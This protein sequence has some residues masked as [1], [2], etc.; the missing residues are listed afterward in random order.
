VKEATTSVR[1]LR[2]RVA[3]LEQLLEVYE[4]SAIATERELERR[5]ADRTIELAGANEQL[6]QEVEERRRAERAMRMVADAGRIM[7]SSL[8]YRR[9][10]RLLIDSILPALGDWCVVD[11]VEDRWLTRIAWGHV[12]PDKQAVLE[13]LNHQYPPRRGSNSLETRVL[14]TGEPLLLR[15]ISEAD[16]ESYTADEE[17]RRLLRE[18]GI[19]SALV[20]PFLARD[21][22]VGSLLAAARDRQL[23]ADELQL[24]G[25]FARRAAAAIDNAALYEAALTAS[26]AKSDFLAVMSHELRTPLNAI[27]GYADLLDAEVKGSLNGEQHRLLE[28][29]HA[30]AAHQLRI[31]EE[32][33]TFVRVEE[34]RETVQ[35]EATELTYLV[36]EVAALIMPQVQDKGLHFER[37]QIP[38]M[39]VLVD[40]TKLREILLSL[41]SNAVKF[42]RAGTIRLSGRVDQGSLVLEVEDSGPG[43]APADHERIFDPFVQIEAPLTRQMGGTGLGLTVARRLAHLMGG[44]IE[45]RSELGSGSTFTVRLPASR[46]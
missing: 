39:R 36:D 21:Q 35:L 7:S 37:D 42:T 3:T 19:D 8:D 26:K 4:Q 11:V 46:V 22:P 31:I 17:H 34:G 38:R 15:S 18:L 41:L 45:V 23:G 1:H 29:I 27:T 14:G 32:I 30:N 25:E 10:F 12:D 6:R 13:E 33:L 24:A 16:L 40:R 43:I 28:R 9:T 2:S 5:V 44:E 20:V